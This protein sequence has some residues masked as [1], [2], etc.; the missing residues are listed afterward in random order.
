[1]FCCNVAPTWPGAVACL[2]T[3]CCCCCWPPGGRCWTTCWPPTW[4]Q[5]RSNLSLLRENSLL[6]ETPTRAPA[7]KQPLPQP[8]HQSNLH[9]RSTREKRDPASRKKPSYT[10]TATTC[11]NCPVEV[12]TIW[13][14]WPCCCWACWAPCGLATSTCRGAFAGVCASRRQYPNF[15]CINWFQ[16]RKM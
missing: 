14:C 13:P 16:F 12:L 11:S 15:E 1:M 2:M 4:T 6:V 3:C 5:S 7:P 10:R 8:Q 9:Q